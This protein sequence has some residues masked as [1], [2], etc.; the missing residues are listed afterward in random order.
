MKNFYRSTIVAIIILVLSVLDFSDIDKEKVELIP[1]LDKIVHFCMYAGLN[2]ILLL[3]FRKQGK[4][5]RFLI[6]STIIACLYGFGMEIIQLTL[7][8]Y[9][10]FEL[11]DFM[12]NCL[13][14]ISSV[15][16]FRFLILKK[17]LF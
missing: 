1:H 3:D 10:G 14:A 6:L 17:N 13:G 8:N 11:L 9:R 16:V 5:N 4:L 2:F 12:T 15:F 7:T